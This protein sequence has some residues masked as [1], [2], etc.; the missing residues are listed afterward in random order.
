MTKLSWW[1]E[2]KALSYPIGTQVNFKCPICKMGR[3]SKEHKK[4]HCSKAI[5]ALY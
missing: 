1:L 3:G 4:G 5:K 2:K